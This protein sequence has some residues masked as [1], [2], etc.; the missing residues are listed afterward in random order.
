LSSA[1]IHG[2]PLIGRPHIFISF[3]TSSV[4]FIRW[5]KG[6]NDRVP[7]PQKSNALD[8]RQ[9]IDTDRTAGKISR[10]RQYLRSCHWIRQLRPVLGTSAPTGRNPP[11]RWPIDSVPLE[12]FVSHSPNYFRAGHRL[13]FSATCYVPP[14]VVDGPKTTSGAFGHAQAALTAAK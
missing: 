14:S 10:L 7:V 12:T 11:T 2:P 3:M 1:V 5:L 8:K 6:Q 9:V 4:N 13:P